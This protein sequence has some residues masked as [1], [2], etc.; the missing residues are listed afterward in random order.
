MVGYYSPR[1]RITGRCASQD[2]LFDVSQAMLDC[3]RLVTQHEAVRAFVDKRSVAPDDGEAIVSLS[4]KR[5]I[6]SL[7]VGRA[8]GATIY[9]RYNDVCWLLA[10]S[11][12][13]ASGERRDAYAYFESLSRR[14]VLLL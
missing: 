6:K 11:P 7:H 9:D 10:F 12:T 5:A 3:R 1:L 2:L 4:R 14:D 13:H 8:R